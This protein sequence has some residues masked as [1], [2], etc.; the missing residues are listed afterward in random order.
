MSGVD[1]DERVLA[2]AV[3][4]HDAL[5][6]EKGPGIRSL[7]VCEEDLRVQVPPVHPDL[8]TEVE[9]VIRLVAKRLVTFAADRLHEGED[10]V[11]NE[12]DAH[13]APD[14]RHEE[15]PRKPS[16]GKQQ[17]GGV[18]AVSPH[19]KHLAPE[20]S[21]ARML[22]VGV[23]EQDVIEVGVVFENRP[24]V[25]ADHGRNIRRR[26]SPPERPDER[27]R[28]DDVPDAI[29]ANHEYAAF[30]GHGVPAG[31]QFGPAASQTTMRRARYGTRL[32]R[33]IPILKTAMAP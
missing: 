23:V 13:A 17:E 8:S 22:A 27:R 12:A 16:R 7:P 26:E 9:T 5:S 20:A 21:P 24:G 10:L 32:K 30:S 11:E 18:E 28:Q 3:P 19:G 4:K 29:G 31:R 25:R 1:A 15:N 2:P 14:A 6:L 33:M